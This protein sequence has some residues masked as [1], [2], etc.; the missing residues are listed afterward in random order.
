MTDKLKIEIETGDNWETG[1]LGTITIINTSNVGISQWSININTN[2][3]KINSIYNFNLSQIDNLCTISNK[4]YNGIIGAGQ[5]ITSGFNYSGSSSDLDYQVFQNIA[6]EQSKE[7]KNYANIPK[8]IIGYFTEWS[9]YQ[10]Q[11]SVE[12]IKAN[13]LTHISYAFMLPNPSQEDYDLFK[14]KSKFPPLPYRPPPEVPEGTL[15]FHDEYAGLQ[16]I[17]KLKKLKNDN[18]HLKIG[19]SVG[20][21][22]LS[23]TFSKVAS[24]PVIRK[25]FI[26]S[27]VN[28]LIKHGFDYLSF[29]WE[30]PQKQGIGFNIVDEKNDGKNLV[31]MLKETREYMDL[32]SPNKRL[33]ITAA[34]GCNP[35]VLEAYKGTNLYLDSLELM[36]YDYAGCWS[37]D[38]GYHTAIYH[39]P[40]DKKNSKEFNL[41]FAFDFCVDYLNYRPDQICAGLAF[42]SR[43]WSGVQRNDPNKIFG[44]TQSSTAGTLSGSYGEPGMSSFRDIKKAI[45]AG[46]IKEHYDPVAKASWYSDDDGNI[47][48]FDSYKTIADK[49]EYV[50]NYHLG[51]F[52][53]WELSDDI[54]SE[55][56]LLDTLHTELLKVKTKKPDVKIDIAESSDDED[57]KSISFDDEIHIIKD[58]KIEITIK[59]NSDKNIILEKGKSMTFACAYP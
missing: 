47:A 6:K 4:D 1:G 26:E 43:G 50:N 12:Q 13:K 27:S 37:K 30:F 24:D 54:R 28:F 45:D 19:I 11:F 16:N 15:V 48:S 40:E 56:G 33:E 3:F 36:S 44:S 59:N 42:Y 31:N 38:T 22:T 5:S 51:G 25:T 20:G 39:N 29:D 49:V 17:E 23:W 53:I 41:D 10:R 14:S 18:P 7:V 57:V 46:K 35:K 8:K 32:K 34:A 2:N 55:G 21:W 58:N 52:L 9:I